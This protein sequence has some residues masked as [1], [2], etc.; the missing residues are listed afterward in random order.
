[1]LHKAHAF[2]LVIGLAGLLAT[3]CSAG[4]GSDS[5]GLSEGAGGVG[6]GGFGF[7]ATGNTG[8]EGGFNSGQGGG[9]GMEGCAHTQ[10]TPQMLEVT[11]FVA[12]DKSGSMADYGKWTAARNAFT[13][14]FSNPAADS[15]KVALA[16]WPLGTCSDPLCDVIGCAQP[17][18]DVGSLS[19][20]GHE[21]ALIGAFNLVSP[22]GG[23]PMSAALAGATG[24][25]VDRQQANPSTERVV[26]VFLTD[27]EPTTC[28]L[29]VNAIAQNA[30]NAF[31]VAEV[32]TF[33]VGLQG[34]F[35]STLNLIAQA[36]GT[37]QG[38]FIGSGNVEGELINALNAI[39]ESVM[40]CTYAMPASG[41]PQNPVDPTK[42][43]VT[44][45]PGGGASTTIPQVPNEAACGAAPGWFYDNPADPHAIT[46]CPA[47]CDQVQI[48]PAGQVDIVLGCTT[49]TY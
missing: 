4:A 13:S 5:S 9:G 28:N 39:R 22:N 12:I 31:A 1:M 33:A 25:A 48:D 47:S 41:D 30:A 32:L 15:L 24:W 34:S 14:F 18:V 7:G 27:G 44:Y 3:A 49:Q 35:E 38:Y 16:F 23:T 37:G 40:A 26:V 19:D 6:S 10:V 17:M 45:T 43:N 36:G 20:G 42:V 8:N 21:L 2:S 11:M 29:N 46:L